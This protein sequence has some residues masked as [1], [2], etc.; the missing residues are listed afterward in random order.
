MP[1]FNSLQSWNLNATTGEWK[2]AGDNNYIKNASFE[3]DRRRI[4]SHVKPVQEQLTG[5]NT[6]VLEGNA[7]SL[8][9]NSS[10]ILNYF[11]TEADR[12]ILTGEKS[13]NITDKINF[14]RTVSQIISSSPNVQLEDG[15]YTMTAIVKNS[16]GF[17]QLEMYALSNNKLQ[18]YDFKSENAGWT[19]IRIERIHVKN[20]KVEIGFRAAGIANTY[21]YVDD[22]SLIKVK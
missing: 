14:K 16:N 20:G 9:S 13:L 11:N 6:T 8:D 19:T 3:A 15:Y 21:C 18:W 5:W 22:V 10:P 17:T 7:V 12:K 1:Y 2:V 4:P